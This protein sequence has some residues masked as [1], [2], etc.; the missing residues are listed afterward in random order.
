MS[1]SS[2]EPE[3]RPPKKSKGKAKEKKT[4]KQRVAITPH[5]KNEAPQTNYEPP[6]GSVLLDTDSDF[7]K[8]DWNTV[9]I[10][11]DLEVWLI[12]V[13]DSVCLDSAS[14]LSHVFTGTS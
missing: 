3:V 13:P 11:K 9:K 10:D 2:P 8:F 6:K 12:R 14:L 4:A 1:S 7:G 5:G